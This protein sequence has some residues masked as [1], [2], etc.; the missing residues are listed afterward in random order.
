[1]AK[2]KVGGNPVP[3]GSLMRA[4]VDVALHPRFETLQRWFPLLAARWRLIS[5]VA[6]LILIGI[7]GLVIATTFPAYSSHTI[8]GLLIWL[9]PAFLGHLVL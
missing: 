7:E 8:P 3:E 5:L 6:T 4:W 9:L 1:M 2:E